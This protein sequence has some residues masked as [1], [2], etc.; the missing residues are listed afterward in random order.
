MLFTELGKEELAVEKRKEFCLGQ[1]DQAGYDSGAHANFMALV[2]GA[3]LY[4]RV[5]SSSIVFGH[6][7]HFLS[8]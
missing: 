1:K 5:H 7:R 4:H 3:G 2:P 8:A 6:R